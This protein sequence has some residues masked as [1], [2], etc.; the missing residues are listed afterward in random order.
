MQGRFEVLE[1][2]LAL[3][4]ALRALVERIQQSDGEL[5]TQLR[6][7]GSSV[8]LCIAEGAQRSGRDRPHLFRVAAG[9][10]AEVRAALRVA[11]A[12]GY[13]EA[14]AVVPAEQLLDRVAAMLWR[15]AHAQR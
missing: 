7:A 15:L 13:L 2:A 1:V 11:V 10:A 6:R 8:P 9:S 12:W 5:A 3:V 4:A 14:A